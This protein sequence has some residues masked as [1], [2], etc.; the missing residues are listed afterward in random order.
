MPTFT[1]V[2]GGAGELPFNILEIHGQG[3]V[4]ND[5]AFTALITRGTSVIEIEVTFTDIGAMESGSGRS[6]RASW[7]WPSVAG[8]YHLVIE[9]DYSSDII[10]ADFQV[11]A[12]ALTTSA[13]V[14]A[15]LDED[16]TDHN[17]S[18]SLAVA[19]KAVA[20]LIPGA[21]E[22]MTF[23][24]EYPSGD[25][26]PRAAFVLRDSDGLRLHTGFMDANGQAQVEMP[27]GEDY[28]IAVSRQDLQF[29]VV[30]FDVPEGGA[31]VT[32]TSEYSSA[33]VAGQ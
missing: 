27:E 5:V 24:A 25:P 4:P 1:G 6:Y 31:T 12:A 30:T 29:A 13:I 28:T 26:V 14:D 2:L 16:L 3:T 32:A 9:H 33:W 10:I 17:V 23:Q 8:V 18:G 15:V 22:L 20:Q 11:G 21:T 19:V 7:T